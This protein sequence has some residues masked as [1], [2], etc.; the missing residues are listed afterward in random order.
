MNL[1]GKEIETARI[2]PSEGPTLVFLHEGLGSLGLWRDFPKRLADATGL[3][4]FVYSRAGYGKSDPAPLPRPVRYMHDEAELLP[5]ILAAAG[6]T[7]PILVGHSDGASI[8]IIYAGSGHAARALVLEAPHVFTE[9]SGLQSI[10]KMRDLYAQTD[11][12]ARLGRHHQNVDAAFLGW[13]GAWLHPE[14][15]KWNLEEYLPHIRKP[16]LIVQGKDDEYGTEKQIEAIQRGVR[17]PAEVVLLPECGHSPHRDKP[18]ET[19]RA[20]ADFVLR[21][22]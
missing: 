10:A 14:F 17:G 11:L 6:L 5:E 7:D 19:L 22:V 9:E 3:G 13:N 15:R 16:L 18:E 20:M 1:H 21:V 2:G 8:A 4:A 12:R